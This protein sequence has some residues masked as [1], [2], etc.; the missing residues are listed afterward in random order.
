MNSHSDNGTLTP[1]PVAQLNDV[2]FET[3]LQSFLSFPPTN[4]GSS[5][6]ALTV[7]DLLGTPLA[8]ELGFHPESFASVSPEPEAE[9]S[10]MSQILSCETPSLSPYSNSRRTS[11]SATSKTPTVFDIDE[12]GGC[13]VLRLIP[14]Q[15]F[16]ILNTD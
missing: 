4:E 11:P 8:R 6:S 14:T 13:D 5:S 3:L 7:A 2:E 10:E 16:D 12:S 1:P 9:Q 15:D